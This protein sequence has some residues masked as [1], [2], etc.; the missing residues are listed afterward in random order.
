MTIMVPNMVLKNTLTVSSQQCL[1]E[2]YLNFSNSIKTLPKQSYYQISVIK[3]LKTGTK[4]KNLTS[5]IK[6]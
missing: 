1:S 5:G 2:E 3:Q 6:I 4:I